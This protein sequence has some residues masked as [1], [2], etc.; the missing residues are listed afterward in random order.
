MFP[1]I[2]IV[3]LIMPMIIVN[4]RRFVV[5]EMTADYTKFALS[6]GLSGKYVFFVHVFRNA[7][8]R[9]VRDI[10][11]MFIITLFGSSILVEQH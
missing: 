6:K 4:T 8:V 5:D 1:V 11:I 10:P 7:G 3:L 2:G 9:L